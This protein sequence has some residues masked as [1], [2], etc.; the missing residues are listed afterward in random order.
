[1]RIPQVT[2]YSTIS[3]H[4]KRIVPLHGG[5]WWLVLLHDPFTV[6]TNIESCCT[7]ATSITLY[8]NF[9]SVLKRE[10]YASGIKKE[11]RT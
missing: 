1:M 4:K 2:S 11:K 5:G 7:P 10:S 6:Y 8:V 3:Y 9:T